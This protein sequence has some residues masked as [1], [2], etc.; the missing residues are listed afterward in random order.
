MGIF[1]KPANAETIEGIWVDQNYL[2]V[3]QN[4][5]SPKAA[6]SASEIPTIT[7]EGDRIFLSLHFHESAEY[8]IK[9]YEEKNGKIILNDNES[10]IN[11]IILTSGNLIVNYQ[12]N[13]QI[14]TA[15][16]IKL[17]SSVNDEE[18]YLSQIVVSGRYRDKDN[19]EYVFQNGNMIWNGKTM[20]YFILFDYV[21][22]IPLSTMCISDKN[23]KNR[24]WY[25]FVTNGVMLQIYK[26][27][28]DAKK[29]IKL[30]LDLEKER[31]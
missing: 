21:E 12:M 18:Q 17:P 20:K 22:F 9:A 26:Y 31:L 8:Q 14:L 6:S 11:S 16:F 30:I 5:L 1:E 29:I 10:F 2:M 28:D 3:L 15:T 19:K 4:S 13:N 25:G 24:V 7:I 23:D 27:D